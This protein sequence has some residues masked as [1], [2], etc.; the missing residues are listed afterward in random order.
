MSGD[1]AVIGAVR[2]AVGGNLNQGAAYVFTRSGTV[3]TQQQ[4]LAASNG[5]AG[6]QFGYSVAVS[7]N[8]AVVGDYFKAVSATSEPGAAYVFTLS[9]G[10]WTQQQELLASDGVDEDHFGFS[11]AV[12]G[13]TAVIGAPTNRRR[14]AWLRQRQR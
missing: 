5:V 7:G 14:I 2:K 9:G 1:T 11:V 6:D 3:W 12:D 10:V 4:E 8:T 13:G